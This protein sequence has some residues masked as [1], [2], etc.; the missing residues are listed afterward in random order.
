MNYI[1]FHHP[2]SDGMM[3]ATIAYQFL[4]Q[5]NQKITM[6]PSPPGKFPLYFPIEYNEPTAG[7]TIYILD[8]CFEP[9][10]LE[11][12]SKQINKNV[13]V[14]DHHE[15]SRN[16]INSYCDGVHDIHRSGCR[17]SW[18][19]F[20]QGICP[21]SSVLYVEDRDLWKWEYLP[22]SKQFND[23]FY[24]MVPI[25]REEYFHYVFSSTHE[26]LILDAIEKGKLLGD[27]IKIQID[28]ISKSAR[29]Q[30]WMNHKTA[31]VNSSL[32]VS[33]VASH[34]LSLKS[35]K[36][37]KSHQNI[38]EPSYSISQSYLYDCA[39]VWHKNEK[40]GQIKVSLR[41]RKNDD[42]TISADVNDLASK[43]GGGGHKT[44]SGFICFDLNDV[45]QDLSQ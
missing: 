42:G 41:S 25:D 37:P 29:D 1:F 27:F 31:F 14:L 38:S 16:W 33:E 8:T 11:I 9:S 21:P 45:F 22:Q 20:Y 26:N 12:L 32:H 6:V 10:T 40:I 36:S 17:L 15:Y 7:D 43:F 30:M 3:A 28:E 19:Y 44:A 5:R 13:I 39:F 4:S 23:Y 18:D 2:C 35:L 24:T 34:L